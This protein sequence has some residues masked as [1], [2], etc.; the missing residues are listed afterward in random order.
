MRENATL[1]RI[2]SVQQK[3]RWQQTR[4]PLRQEGCSHFAPPTDHEDPFGRLSRPKKGGMYRQLVVLLRLA[5]TDSEYHLGLLQ[6]API[7]NRLL[8]LLVRVSRHPLNTIDGNYRLLTVVISSSCIQ[9]DLVPLIILVSI[10]GSID[11]SRRQSPRS[12]HNIWFFVSC[13]RC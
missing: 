2:H 1:G 13:F 4:T 3:Q 12:S 6:V 9:V 7:S 10:P 5:R 8:E 11:K